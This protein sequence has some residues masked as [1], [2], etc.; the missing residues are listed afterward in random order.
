VKPEPRPEPVAVVRK[1]A[2]PIAVAH[3]LAPKPAPTPSPAAP[4]VSGGPGFLTLRSEPWCE[5]TIDGARFGATPLVHLSM[6]SGKHKV[7]L[8]NEAV[9]AHRELALTVKP[10]EELKQ[11]VL[12]AM[13]RLVVTV[14][15]WAQVTVDGRA[16][17]ATPIEPVEL[18]AG[19]HDVRLVNSELAKDERRRVVVPEGKDAVLKVIWE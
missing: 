6:P 18:S 12:F 3:P 5:V 11:S 9:G 19:V 7:L 8:D 10:G 13:G 14:K 1:P 15:P 16:I 2:A 17:G 4:A